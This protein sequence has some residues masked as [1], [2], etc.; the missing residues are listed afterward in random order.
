MR[1]G[2]LERRGETADPIKKKI[3]FDYSRNILDNDSA[4]QESS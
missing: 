3:Q 1:G 2:D 4:E